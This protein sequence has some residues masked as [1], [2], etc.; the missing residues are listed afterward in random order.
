MISP[1]VLYSWNGSLRNN[2]VRKEQPLESNFMNLYF[3]PSLRFSPYLPPYLHF[4]THFLP[5]PLL[6]T[7]E[8]F[9]PRTKQFE[10]GNV[11]FIYLRLFHL[12]LLLLLLFLFFP[13]LF[14]FSPLLL[15]PSL[16]LACFILNKTRA[17]CFRATRN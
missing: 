9:E 11:V 15:P 16:L 4:P 17:R 1:P 14:F 5:S 3:R 2:L 6:S 13:F 10:P 7:L 8:R 12:L